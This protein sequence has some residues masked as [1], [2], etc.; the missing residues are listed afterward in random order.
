MDTDAKFMTR[1][2]DLARK[3]LGLVEPNPMVG[4]VIVGGGQELA[5]GYHRKYGGPH[6]EI[7][8]LRAAERAGIDVRGA[9]MYVTVEPCCHHGKTGPCTEAIIFAE[10]GRVVVAMADPDEN[11]SGKGI[12]QLL[13]AGIEVDVGICQGLA[14][15]LLGA[16]IKSRTKFQPWIICKWAQ[17]ADGALALP[18]GQGRWISC[19]QSRKRVHEIRAYCDGICVGVDTVLADDPL[20][21][22][23]SGSPK[24]LTRIVLDGNLR[25][26]IDSRLVKTAGQG[27]LLVAT[28][29]RALAGEAEKADQLR[30]L[31]AELIPL[32]Q[33]QTGVDL[34]ALLENLGRRGWT[35]LLVEGGP[36]ILR[37]FI[38]TGLADELLVFVSPTT[39]GSDEGL[40]RLDISELQARLNLPEPQAEE[41]GTDR[42]LRFVLA[43]T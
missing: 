12:D 33:C 10:I 40:P 9:T 4:A 41:S 26:P 8:A 32:P 11:V 22:N 27:Q 6:A 17:T 31:G 28:T 15:E 19:D 37:S 14:H 5:G 39:A 29:E 1:T 25:I 20:L 21:T 30:K 2:I 13:R 7:E 36:T 42:L 38:D 35:Y 18:A 24:G 23:R 3:G 16:Y 34:E 43:G